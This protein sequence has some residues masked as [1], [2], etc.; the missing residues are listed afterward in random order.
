MS[1]KTADELRDEMAAK[2][3]KHANLSS[4]VFIRNA[5]VDRLLL[6]LIGNPKV[7][8]E[9]VEKFNKSGFKVEQ[10]G[11]MI[12]DPDDIEYSCVYFTLFLKG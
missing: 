1:D 11:T 4:E 12:V 8:T 5:F 10:D 6:T 3:K 9:D 7:L 2:I